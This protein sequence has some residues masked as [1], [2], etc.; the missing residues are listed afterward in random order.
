MSISYKYDITLRNEDVVDYII[1]LSK[2]E[3]V[4]CTLD[5]IYLF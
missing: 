2:I 5:H 4:K 3:A 1:S